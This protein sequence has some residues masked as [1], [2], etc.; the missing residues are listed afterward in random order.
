[1]PPLC[2]SNNFFLGR[3]KR[4]KSARPPNL[5][6]SC[7]AFDLNPG[8]RTGHDIVNNRKISEK[9]QNS[10]SPHFPPLL[11]LPVLSPP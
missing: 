11:F 8:N 4:K 6:S 3:Q 9:S 2:K 1:M 10:K 5:C 7:H